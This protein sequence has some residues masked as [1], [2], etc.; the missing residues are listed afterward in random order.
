MKEIFCAIGDFFS[1]I[2]MGVETIGNSI[3]Y[4]YICIIFLFLIIWTAKMLKH[5]KDKEEHAPL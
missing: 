2:F 1:L 3:N 5:R 4:L